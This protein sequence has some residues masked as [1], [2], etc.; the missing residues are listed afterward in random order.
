MAIVTTV[1][2]KGEASKAYEIPDEELS[3]Y[4]EVEAQQ[5]QYEGAPPEG[6]EKSD[7]NQL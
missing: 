6:A 1:P 2:K 7:E 3:K 4:Q 5:T